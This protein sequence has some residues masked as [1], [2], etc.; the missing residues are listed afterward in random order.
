MKLPVH[1]LFFVAV[2]LISMASGFPSA[3]AQVSTEA[4][5]IVVQTGHTNSIEEVAISPDGQFVVTASEDGT[6][7]VWDGPTARLRFILAH[8][9]TEVENL[10]ISDDGSTIVTGGED[11]RVVIW[12]SQTGEQRQILELEGHGRYV[13]VNRDGSRVVTVPGGVK[14]WNGVTGELVAELS[15]GYYPPLFSPDGS[16]VISGSDVYDASIGQSA[17]RIAAN[18]EGT[19]ISQDSA[20]ILGLEEGSAILFSSASGDALHQLVNPDGRPAVTAAFSTSGESIS[21]GYLD[22]TV[23]IWS[24]QGELLQS[25]ALIDSLEQIDIE[26]LVEAS[27]MGSEESSSGEGSSDGNSNPLRDLQLTDTLLLDQ[28]RLLIAF[29]RPGLALICDLEGEQ[30]CRAEG[31][32]GF[33][34]R[35]ADGDRLV[36]G[37]RWSPRLWDPVTGELGPAFARLTSTIQDIGIG[38]D[39]TQLLTLHVWEDPA[40]VSI[41]QANADGIEVNPTE[42][43]EPEQF[44]AAVRPV[45]QWVRAERCMADDRTADDGSQTT[46]V[47]GLETFEE[48]AQ[49]PGSP[50]VIDELCT[51]IATVAEDGQTVTLYELPSGERLQQLEH[52]GSVEHGVFSQDSSLLITA[53]GYTVETVWIWRLDTGLLVHELTGFAVRGEDVTVSPDGRFV[54]TGSGTGSLRLWDVQTG[55]VLYTMAPAGRLSF[56]SYFPAFSTPFSPDGCWLATLDC[57]EWRDCEAGGARMWELES[58]EELLSVEHEVG[59]VSVTTFS[60]SGNHLVS[61]GDDGSCRLWDPTT[62]EEVVRLYS[63]ANGEWAVLG[64]NDHWEAANG[65]AIMGITVWFEDRW[66]TLADLPHLRDP[67]LLGRVLGDQTP[68]PPC[69]DSL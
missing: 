44:S 14:L 7:R 59:T 30:L 15:G 10:A 11:D 24:V 3:F 67:G 62:G 50:V 60:A 33:F 69:G 1:S 25:I 23:G 6:A 12:D 16:F 63:F 22:L 8:G 58:G 41:W 43:F 65:G 2:A 32:A 42:I 21:V 28:P 64:P 29:F 18:L 61:C 52:T 35:T 51:R 19:S 5:R 54:V 45:S 48:L 49:I 53:S 36:V 66:A 56:D 17:Y 68:L 26:A 20:H 39:S 13:A 47:Y 34:D 38:R 31:I 37:D 9:E 55:E 57:G 4:Y 40:F 27:G 46:I